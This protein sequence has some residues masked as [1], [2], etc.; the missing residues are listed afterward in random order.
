[1]SIEEQ[2]V[3]AIARKQNRLRL[4]G[5]KRTLFKSREMNVKK[6][7]RPRATSDCNGLHV[8]L[9]SA[10]L[11][12]VVDGEKEPVTVRDGQQPPV[13]DSL[14]RAYACS[15]VTRALGS[16]RFG[17]PIVCSQL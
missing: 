9:S 11:D 12:K 6:R 10:D 8:E 15:S 17:T 5:E 16:V 1:M 4:V 14:S 2:V 13:P 3:S 7:R